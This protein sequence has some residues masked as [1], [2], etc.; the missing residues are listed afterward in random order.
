MSIRKL[1]EQ[2][3]SG[4]TSALSVADTA[5]SRIAEANP[6]LNAFVYVDAEG[7][8]AAARD[9]DRRV[10]NG[11]RLALAGVPVGVKDT[12]W[13][14]GY[15]VAQ[16]SRLF[17]GF[18]PAHDAIV[19]ERL[20]QSG[21][22]VIGIT[23][24]PEFASKGHTN[25]PFHGATRHPS[26]MAL[27]P[28][29]SS[30]GSAAAVAAHM[31]PLA[32]GTDVG[33]S[34]RRPAAHVGICGF[35]PSYG[36]IPY[37]PGF[38]EPPLGIS[39]IG[40]MAATVDDLS[41][42]F[43]ATVGTDRRD[44]D[45]IVISSDPPER[46][47]RVAYSPRFGIE[48]PIDRDVEEAV[49]N[50]VER[51]RVAGVLIVKKDPVWPDG[52]SEEALMAMHFAGLAA[53][54]GERWQQSPDLFDPEIGLQ[55]ERGLTMSGLEVAAGRMRSLEFIEAAS[56]FFSD[57]DILL[58]PTTPCTAW[59]IEEPGPATI[60]GIEALPRAHAV[61]TPFFNHARTP[62]ISVPCGAGR[63]NL[64]VGMQLAAARGNDRLLLAFARDAQPILGDG[65]GRVS[66]CQ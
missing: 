16:G 34:T 45:S 57:I 4:T 46:V 8:R 3:T 9:V 27:T 36:T 56:G 64:P 58:G 24:A 12:I 42:A 54:Y 13:V 19:V 49:E 33:G 66:A 37:G 62:A 52:A 2:V 32:L 7:A 10:A 28:G 11:E 31:V 14:A 48:T 65:G 38:D 35:K 20:R 39:V 50:A 29:G 61:F 17:D 63:N 18:R 44:P 41:I 1:V 55:I 22:V 59:S 40:L 25:S 15:R 5:L 30:G 51:L 53:I 23:N 43:E 47:A 6:S 21:A 26:N 60:G